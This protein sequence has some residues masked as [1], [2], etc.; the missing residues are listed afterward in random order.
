MLVPALQPAVRSIGLLR[1]EEVG[2][3]R[4]YFILS[5]RRGDIHAF[6][7]DEEKEDEFLNFGI[8]LKRLESEGATKAAFLALSNNRNLLSQLARSIS[9]VEHLHNLNGLA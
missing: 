9:S 6:K 7:D 5:L 3:F 4:N 2:C 1:R 8:G